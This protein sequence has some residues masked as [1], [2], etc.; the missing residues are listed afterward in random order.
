[1]ANLGINTSVR[2][3]LS[4]KEPSISRENG[5]LTRGEFYVHYVGSARETASETGGEP[6]RA[7]TGSWSGTWTKAT[8]WGE[9]RVDSVWQGNGNR[10]ERPTAEKLPFHMIIH[11]N[12]NDLI[13]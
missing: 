1:M 11:E 4:E 12:K 13:S 8:A 6:L 10:R 3:N 5:P 2:K 9:S 7:R